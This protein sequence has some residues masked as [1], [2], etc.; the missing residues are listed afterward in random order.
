MIYNDSDVR[1]IPNDFNESVKNG[2]SFNLINMSYIGSL[3]A[4]P[5]YLLAAKVSIRGNKNS[6]F[7]EASRI[8]T[9]PL[10]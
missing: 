2:S 5:A 4:L 3:I 10:D 7:P 1:Y 8:I 6:L 9:V